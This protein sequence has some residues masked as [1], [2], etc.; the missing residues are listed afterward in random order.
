MV[1]VTQRISQIKQPRGGYIKP[2]QFN[3]FEYQDEFTLNENEN[4]HATVIGLAVDYLTRFIMGANVSDAFKISLKGA[5]IAEKNFKQ[6]KA[7]QTATNLISNI[8]SLD[9]KSIISCCK[10]VTYDVWYRNHIAALK[11]KGV[12]ETNPNPDTIQNIK[13]LVERSL[14]FWNEYGPIIKDGFTFEPSGYTKSV[15]TGDGDYLTADTLWDFKVSKDK[16]SNRHT[17]Q[18]LM[19]WIMGQHSGQDI[20]TNIT[21]LGIFNP[22]LNKVYTIDMSSISKEAIEEIEREII[23]Y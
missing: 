8:T 12:E 23:C 1:S 13:I 4:I 15:N 7:I 6:N 10:L 22:R 18:L 2:S 19:Y 11:A 5:N 21:K 17:L 3:F 9:E 20:F 16:P 14:K